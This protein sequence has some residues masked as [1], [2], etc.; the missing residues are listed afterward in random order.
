MAKIAVEL[1]QALAY[2]ELS[3]GP[4]TPSSRLLAQGSGWTVQDVICTSGPR[5]RAFEEQHSRISISIVAAGT[6][7]YRSTTGRELMTP[8]SLMLGNPGQ[9]FECGHDHGRG[10]RCLSFGYTP[11][12]F[13]TLTG[14]ARFPALRLPPL[15]ALSPLVTRACA[16]LT[17]DIAWEELSVQL[18]AQT[19]SIVV[20][21]KSNPNP[22]AEARVARVVRAIERDP[23]AAHTLSDLASEVGLSPYH[24]LRAFEQVTGVTPHQFIL[25]TRLREAALRLSEP[26]RILDIALDSGFG[27]LS[28][29][30]RT[31]RA[32]FGISPK[33]WRKLQ[34]RGSLRTCF[35]FSS[36]SA[37]E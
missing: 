21:E 25:R 10:D 32:E 27:D 14:G 23:T 17:K 9:C 30:N 3:G 22:S 36:I 11:E 7:Q 34:P 8:G 19:L 2:R 24:F 4:A 6:F 28:N 37:A 26:A 15:R 29:F 13:E 16:G 1:E 31:F 5:D 35:T 20:G 12:Y 18:A 33:A